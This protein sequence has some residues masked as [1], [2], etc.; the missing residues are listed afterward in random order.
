MSGKQGGGW[1]YEVRYR[2]TKVVKRPKSAVE[3]AKTVVGCNA[4]Y[5]LPRPMAVLSE[6]R[7]MR[8]LR[9]E[10]VAALKRAS[11]D[12]SLLAGVRFDGQR[13][14]QE[15]ATPIG[16]RLEAVD[17]TARRELLD[18]C[19]DCLF[20]CW[21]QGLCDGSYSFADNYGVLEGR[22][23]LLDVGELHFSKRSVA[24]DVS[25]R[26]WIGSYTDQ[27]LSPSDRD[28]L[29]SQMGRRVTVDRLDRIWATEAVADPHRP[30][31]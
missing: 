18:R 16:E 22:V 8:R 6:V 24:R 15:R 25:E 9:R 27:W 30:S 5:Y 26:P 28:Y 1:Q 4:T 7:R 14:I 23:V 13:V 12:R 2:G 11:V 31:G 29:R 21:R 3:I 19:I 20:D 10:S 17:E